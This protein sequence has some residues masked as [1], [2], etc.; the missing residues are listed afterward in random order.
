LAAKPVSAQPLFYQLFTESQPSFDAVGKNTNPKEEIRIM[1]NQ[2]PASEVRISNIKCLPRQKSVG[3]LSH[4]T[5][6]FFKHL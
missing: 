3:F 6:L 4:A 5:S 2:K 1:A